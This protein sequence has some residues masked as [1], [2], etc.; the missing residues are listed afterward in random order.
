MPAA[1]PYTP[2]NVAAELAMLGET[3]RRQRKV[4]GVA[5][6]TVAQAAGI[7]RVTLHRIEKGEPAVT[8]GAYLNAAA[9]VGL[10]FYAS[11]S[12]AQ[13]DALQHDTIPVEIDLAAYPQLAKLAWQIRSDGRLRPLEA[14]GIYERNWR[15]IDQAALTDQERRLIAALERAVGDKLSV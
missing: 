10:H 5:A 6:Q 2:E 7:S 11:R 8:I 14:W 3:I 15:H 1:A 12:N 13:I 4:L 9:A